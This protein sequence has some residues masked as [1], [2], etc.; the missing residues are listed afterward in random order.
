M[1]ARGSE[2]EPHGGVGRHPALG[3][4]T[5]RWLEAPAG[6][7]AFAR[8]PGFACIVNFTAE[9]VA[10]PVHSE[11]LIASGPLDE[12]GRVPADTA[13]WLAL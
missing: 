6:A 1:P 5:L 8:A 3:D 9:P 2:G 13:V 11:R 10:P 4:G 7:L 12:D